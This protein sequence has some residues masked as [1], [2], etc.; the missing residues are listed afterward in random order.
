VRV[1]VVCVCVCGCVRA[2]LLCVTKTTIWGRSL[3]EHVD[4]IILAK[5]SCWGVI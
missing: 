1:C 4:V 5:G 3:V 2:K